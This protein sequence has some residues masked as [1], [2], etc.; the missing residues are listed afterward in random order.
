[1]I[2]EDADRRV[3]RAGEVYNYLH[4]LTGGDREFAK[5]IAIK[6]FNDETTQP[7]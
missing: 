7:V 5:D 6:I 2:V 1:M 4:Q 3:V